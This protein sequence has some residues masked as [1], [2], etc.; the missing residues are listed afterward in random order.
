MKYL[1]VINCTFGSVLK[2]G[3]VF[4]ELFEKRRQEKVCVSYL[5]VAHDLQQA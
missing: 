1:E 3:N 2:A 5:K 4:L